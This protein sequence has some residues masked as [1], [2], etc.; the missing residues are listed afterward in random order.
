MLFDMDDSKI[1]ALAGIRNFLKGTTG[2]KIKGPSRDEKYSS[3]TARGGTDASLRDTAIAQVHPA[4]HA[5]GH[6]W[7]E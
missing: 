5:R 3:L 1:T 7:F 4:L 6:H 2:L